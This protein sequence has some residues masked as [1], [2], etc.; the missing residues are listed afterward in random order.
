MDKKDWYKFQSN[1]IISINEFFQN[2]NKA[3]KH[4]K[5][6]LY[7]QDKSYLLKEIY[8]FTRNYDFIKGEFLVN[9]IYS[10]KN[11]LLSIL[12]SYRLFQR[13]SFG[14]Y[15]IIPLNKILEYSVENQSNLYNEINIR[16]NN[17]KKIVIRNLLYC[18]DEYEI[19]NVLDM[20]EWKKLSDDE[21]KLLSLKKVEEFKSIEFIENK[22]KNWKSEGYDII[23]LEKMLKIIKNPNTCL[24]CGKELKDGDVYCSIC[25]IKIIKKND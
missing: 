11:I 12:T 8:P 4:E 16:L 5:S 23:E 25:G 17:G 18:L 3:Y 7:I 24:S 22:I 21:L 20:K 2:T 10:P 6:E 9:Y 13:D 1:S 14:K 15:H 19:N